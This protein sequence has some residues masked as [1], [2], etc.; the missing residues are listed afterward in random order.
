[1]WFLLQVTYTREDGLLINATGTETIGGEPSL[2]YETS[3]EWV[4]KFD[5]NSTTPYAC[6]YDPTNA[7]HVLMDLPYRTVTIVLVCIAGGFMLLVP[8]L[9]CVTTYVRGARSGY[10]QIKF[11]PI[12]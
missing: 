5:L 8:L 12:S 1:M 6:F 3:L 2:P 9:V 11:R 4:D 10:N 7:T